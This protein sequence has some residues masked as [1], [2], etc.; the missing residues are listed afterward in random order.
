MTSAHVDPSTVHLRALRDADLE[1]LY[2]W[3]NDPEV[4]RHLARL[5]M[6]REQVK[7][8][9]D[10]LRPEAGD[11]AYAIL[12]G[13]AFVGYAMLNESDP[14]NKKCQAGIVIG[15]KTRWGQGIGSVVARE[16]ARIAFTEGG[17]HRVLAVASERNRGSI[18]CFKRAGYRE[19]GRLRDA[20]LR[21]GEHFDLVLLSLLEPEW[22]SAGQRRVVRDGR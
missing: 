10:S 16:L 18:S 4:T 2:V 7:A 1:S 17:L 20:N 15:D 6:T 8:W 19:E 22:R 13:N 12:V 21:D 11:R 14:M 5:S 3:R 9:Y